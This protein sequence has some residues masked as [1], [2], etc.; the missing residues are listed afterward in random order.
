MVMYRITKD[1][2]D[3][4]ASRLYVQ[5]L[6][7]TASLQLIH[8]THLVFDKNRLAAYETQGSHTSRKSLI[9]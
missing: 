3:V 7:Y 8:G 5:L 2:K 9:V 6:A 4:L 1:E